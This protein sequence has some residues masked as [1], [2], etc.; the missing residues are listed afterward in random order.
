MPSSY[1]SLTFEII[2]DNY[3]KQRILVWF[4]QGYIAPTIR[5]HLED[6][7]I[8]VSRRRVLKFLKLDLFMGLISRQP[9]KGRK[10][11]IEDELKEI[12]G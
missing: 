2:L 10:T 3:S 8:W 9:G 11:K 6:E 12:F 1:L 7:L 4:F 5:R